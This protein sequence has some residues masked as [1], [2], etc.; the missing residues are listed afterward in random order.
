MIMIKYDNNKNSSN[1]NNN[2]VY[3]SEL[4]SAGY[5]KSNTQFNIK[6]NITLNQ[7]K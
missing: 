6:S 3:P 4:V 5:A 2:F 7:V 1:N